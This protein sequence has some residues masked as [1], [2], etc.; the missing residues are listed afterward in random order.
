MML[1]MIRGLARSVT[2][3]ELGI[4]MVR[5]SLPELCVSPGHSF[6]TH[7][8]LARAKGAGGRRR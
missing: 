2:V 5:P 1:A 7:G 8:A 6:V 3:G 4:R